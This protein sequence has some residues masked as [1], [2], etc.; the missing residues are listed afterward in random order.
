MASGGTIKI[1]VEPGP[2]MTEAIRRIVREEVA[3]IAENGAKH[4]LACPEGCHVTAVM[5]FLA[6]EAHD[7]GVQV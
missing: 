4:H 6:Y 5:Q 7:I 1:N 2:S 3:A